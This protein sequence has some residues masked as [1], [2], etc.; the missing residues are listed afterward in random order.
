[1]ISSYV[2]FE[3]LKWNI[4]S[5][6]DNINALLSPDR[7]LIMTS[8]AGSG[9]EPAERVTQ[10]EARCGALE[11]TVDQLLRRVAAL[12]GQQS[13]GTG[14]GVEVTPF[15]CSMVQP[16]LEPTD[17][18]IP[19]RTVSFHCSSSE[20][21]HFGQDET[22]P[23]DSTMAG[24]VDIDDLLREAQQVGE[25]I[26]DDDVREIV[27]YYVIQSPTAAIA[28]PDEIV[29]ELGEL[30]GEA[31]FQDVLLERPF[32]VDPC[33]EELGAAGDKKQDED[34]DQDYDP[35]G[36]IVEGGTLHLILGDSLAVYLVPQL[37]PNE[38]I[39]NLAVRGNTWAK[40]RS[41]IDQHLRE[42]EQEATKKKLR[43]GKVFIWLGGNDEYGRPG[44]RSA[45]IDESN[46]HRVLRKLT[47]HM[48]LL[49]GPTPRLWSDCGR[50]Y[51][52]TPAYRANNALRRAAAA[53]G[54]RV[55]VVP[56]LG[57]ALTSMCRGQH[58]VK[59]EVAAAWYST[60]GVHLSQLGYQKVVKKLGAVFN[61]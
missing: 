23:V 58:V 60:D 1:M 29:Q 56:Y 14:Q 18:P 50:R 32:E 27:D 12:E 30:L 20:E 40:E 47:H 54:A 34:K 38:C 55:R 36:N 16:S 15:D 52:H 10:L 17:E 35:E 22:K 19:I 2:N 24:G 41:L 42:W 53:H 9:G 31:A 11:T 13:A 8:G 25:G 57:R 45:G 46:V 44:E 37:G 39:I 26:Y 51:E 5:L 43:T 49:A 21:D 4:S 3:H 59:Q 28:G 7:L 61:G 33:P 48:V 6:L